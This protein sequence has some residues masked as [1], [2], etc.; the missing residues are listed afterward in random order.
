[1][2]MANVNAQ[3]F[4][5]LNSTELLLAHPDVKSADSNLQAYQAQLLKAGQKMA[6]DFQKN[7]EAYAKEAQKGTLSKIQ[8]QEREG[9]LTQEQNKIREYEIQMQ[10]KLGQKREELYKPILDKIQNAINAVGKENG[11]TF[12]FDSGTG[13]ILHAEDSENII[14]LVKTKLGL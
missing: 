2:F 3:K 1:M 9:K 6:T 7:Y 4:G 12:I 10:Q 8:M 11:F 13:G 5:Y 14:G